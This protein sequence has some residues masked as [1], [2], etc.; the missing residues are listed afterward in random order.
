MSYEPFLIIVKEDLHKKAG[1][2]E[3]GSWQELPKKAAQKLHQ[4]KAAF[5]ELEE[6]LAQEGVFIRGT[7]VVLIHPEISMHNRIVREI[8]H[9]LNVEFGCI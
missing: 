8:L 4:R 5:K 3:E 9:E 1:V 2:I 6:S 7:K